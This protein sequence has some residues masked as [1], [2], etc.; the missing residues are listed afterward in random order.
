MKKIPLVGYPEPKGHYTPAVEASGLVFASG[1]LPIDPKTGIAVNENFKDQ[2]D[3]LFNNV[4]ELLRSAG[5][6]KEDVVRTNAYISSVSLWDAFNSAYSTFF[7]DHKPAR[8]VLP[9]GGKL[10]YGLDVELDFIAER[11][12]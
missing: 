5:C 6:E 2:L 1:I 12:K 4:T 3:T 10:H 11:R 7:G 8:T 9:L